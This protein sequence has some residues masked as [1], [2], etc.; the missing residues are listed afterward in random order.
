MLGKRQKLK[1]EAV[2]NE[3]E[4]TTDFE[5]KKRSLCNAACFWST[6]FT[7][8]LIGTYYVPSICLTFY[9]RWLFQVI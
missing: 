5:E 7:S 2:E 4:E 1:Y 3:E 6:L 8:I 9:Q